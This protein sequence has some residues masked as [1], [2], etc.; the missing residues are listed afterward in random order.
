MPSD[1]LPA[2]SY[3]S[4]LNDVS[5][6]SNMEAIPTFVAKDMSLVELDKAKTDFLKIYNKEAEEAQKGFERAVTAEDKVLSLR[7]D[8][9]FQAQKLEEL[10][11]S[12]G[13]D[14]RLFNLKEED[15]NN[16]YKIK[17][18]ESKAARFV[19]DPNYLS[20]VRDQQYW[21][22]YQKD[23]QNVCAGDKANSTLC[24]M[25][26]Q[27]A[28]Q[29]LADFD[30]AT[31]GMSLQ[32]ADYMP[33]DITKDIK[34]DVENL[35]D[36]KYLSDPQ[37]SGRSMTMEELTKKSR[38][39]VYT[40]ISN[41][42]KDRR[43]KN[44]LVADGF[45]TD[46]KQNEYINRLADEY[47]KENVSK[48]QFK[49]MPT[50]SSGAGFAPTTAPQ[51]M[52]YFGH[53]RSAILPLYNDYMRTKK[54]PDASKLQSTYGGVGQAFNAAMAWLDKTN[55]NESGSIARRIQSLNEG[56]ATG[57]DTIEK[58]KM[59]GYQKSLLAGNPYVIDIVSAGNEK[60][61][62]DLNTIRIL[63]A[64]D[65]NQ[66]NGGLNPADFKIWKQKVQAIKSKTGIDLTADPAMLKKLID[67]A[68]GQMQFNQADISLP[69]V[70]GGISDP[71]DYYYTGPK[72]GAFGNT[73]VQQQTQTPQQAQQANQP[74]PTQMK[75]AGNGLFQKK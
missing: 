46:Q 28:D 48:W 2:S 67:G 51:E 66:T 34:T 16:P 10:K 55:P 58:V 33:M 38:D 69:G 73:G 36:H 21:D 52:G 32:A 19:S 40:V 8:N 22:Q 37:M 14:G 31:P 64:Y 49:L 18:I 70:F 75:P 30:G 53:I 57:G 7:K 71:L 17:E 4:F 61:Q 39:L 47:A 26:K 42:L 1:L 72:A 24:A 56:T 62:P 5:Y 63:R 20:I 44:N 74:A 35:P 13:F 25:A 27:K 43:F 29:Y 41:K 68:N 59:D 3:M 15:F 60:A 65:M 54:G 23:I 6:S 50:A 9:D 11:S 45:D 12:L